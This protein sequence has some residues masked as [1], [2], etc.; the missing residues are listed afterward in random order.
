MNE[1]DPLMREYSGSVPGASVLVVRN[2]EV[3]FRRSYGMANLEEH[4]AAT[5]DTNYRLASVTKQFTAA[6]IL[7]LA[8]QGKLSIDD[9]ITK[10]LGLPH[11]AEAITI[12]H[13][14]THTSGLFAYEDLIPEGTTRQLKD[15][16]VLRILKDDDGSYFAPGTQ[17]RYSNTGYAFLALIVERASGQRFADFLRANIFEPSGMRATV[18]FE[19]GISTVAHR[20]YGYSREG[21][22]WRRTDQ[23]LTSAVLGDGGIYTSIDDLVHW[24]AWLDSGRFDEALVP[25]TRTDDPAVRYGFGWRISE[26]ARRRLVSHTGET[27]GFRNAIVRFPDQ[28]LAVVVLTNRNEGEPYKIATAIADIVLAQ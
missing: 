26:H 6:A 21:D 11:Y 15:A 7:I 19:E 17:Y 23:S 16:D 9:P 13:L 1:I 28:H 8:K 12:R 2:G 27:I 25:A 14:L 22:H 4:I 20:A 3:V 18:A 5:P 24:I 10:Y